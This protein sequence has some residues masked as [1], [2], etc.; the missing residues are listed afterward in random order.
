MR[1]SELPATKPLISCLC[2]THERP[3]FMPWLLWNFDRQTYP[4]K[5]L[6]IVDSSKRPF[7]RKHPRVRVIHA[8][9]ANIPQKRNIALA[10][11]GGDFITWLDDDDWAHPTRLQTLADLIGHNTLAGGRWS[12]FVDLQ[13]TAVT[14]FCDRTG[15]LFACL[16]A[17][18][19][20][21][22][23][24]PFDESE[25]R[26]S[27][28]TWRETILAQNAYAFTYDPLAFFLCHDRNSGNVATAHTFNRPFDDVVDLVG[29]ADLGDT[30][31][32]LEALKSRLWK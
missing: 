16:L 3:E 2:V 5:E 6:I 8:P 14:R 28:L 32:Q 29:T 22:R 21:A 4:N 1:T 25:I 18:T 20:V 17:K 12:W 27:D 30:I 15:V 10:E 23:A 11:A 9:D 13:T 31:H 19:A 26:G 24:V 7:A